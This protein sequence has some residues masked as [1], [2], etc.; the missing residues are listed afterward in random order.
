MALEVSTMLPWT[1]WLWV[2]TQY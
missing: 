2:T 1:T